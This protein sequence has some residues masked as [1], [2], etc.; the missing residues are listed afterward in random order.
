M[1][2][3]AQPRDAHAAQAHR[4]GRG[5][6]G[7]GPRALA[8]ALRCTWG[9]ALLRRCITASLALR[10]AALLRLWLCAADAALLA[11]LALQRWRCA[12]LHLGCCATFQ[13]WA[14]H[15]RAAAGPA[16][17]LRACHALARKFAIIGWQSRALTAAL[18]PPLLPP[19]PQASHL[20]ALLMGDK[21]RGAE[22]KGRSCGS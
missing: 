3:D 12:A 1:G 14:N 19:L 2:D 5:G 20:F 11:L 6:G 21:V 17:A 10:W 7:A 13:A 15:T 4:G 9:A 16:S 22:I 8:L 18:L